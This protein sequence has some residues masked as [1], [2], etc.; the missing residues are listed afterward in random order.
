M[1]CRRAARWLVLLALGAFAATPCRGQ[2]LYV[3]AGDSVSLCETGVFRVSPAGTFKIFPAP[4]KTEF[5]GLAMDSHGNLYVSTGHLEG[6]NKDQIIK[7][8]PDSQ[9]SVFA[10]APN[11]AHMVC[12]AHD[13]LYE[14]EDQIEIYRI[15]PAGKKSF[16]AEVPSGE[17]PEL[18]GLAVDRHGNLYVSATAPF[19]DRIVKVTPS[20]R[21]RVFAVMPGWTHP[22]GLA[23]DAR[24]N[25]YVAS[26]NHTRVTRF[27]D[28]Q[29]DEPL[30]SRVLKF[31]PGGKRRTFAIIPGSD[32]LEGLACDAHGNLYVA[33]YSHG[34]VFK[35]NASG[36]AV[37]TLI[38]TIGEPI[39]IVCKDSSTPKKAVR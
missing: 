29:L 4:A 14:I 37:A 22:A 13:N 2:T 27:K 15:T 3:A 1:I 28:G 24:G 33:D 36:S 11:V 10:N 32:V 19:H 23:L 17:E 9:A 16:V 25:L 31:T 26:W 7:I 30:P 38:T 35:I 39:S 18:H 8:T 12:D 20:G 5:G 21:Q 34:R 6:E